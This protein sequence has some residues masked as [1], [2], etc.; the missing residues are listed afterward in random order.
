MIVDMLPYANHMALATSLLERYKAAP[1]YWGW[2]R[3]EPLSQ[4]RQALLSTL[5]QEHQRLWL[6]L[7]TTPEAD[8]ASTTERWLEDHAFRVEE[9]WLSPAMRL[10]RYQLPEDEP[11]DT[12]QA[13]LDLRLGDR[14]R[15]AGYNPA[16]PLEVKSGEALPFSLFWQTDEPGEQDY[17]VFVQLLGQ[18]GELLAQVDRTPVGG[19]RPTSTWQPGEVIRDNYGLALPPDLLPGRYQLIVGLYSPGSMQRL[20][21]STVEGVQM[22][23]YVALAEVIVRGEEGP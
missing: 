3:E 23:D 15:L 6:A 22:D 10:V 21:V 17:V 12:P 5:V 8:P 19:F 11:D 7:D 1:A 20:A 4:E 9:Q 2:A 16:G 14:L 13:P 18:G